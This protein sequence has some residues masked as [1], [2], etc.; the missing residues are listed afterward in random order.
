M[1]PKEIVQ[2]LLSDIRNP[3]TVRDLCAPDVTYVSL[4]YSNPDLHK[5]MPWCGTGNGVDA[6]SKT[7]HDVSEYWNVDSFSPEALFGENETVAVFG[8]FTYTSTKLRKTVTS[9]FAIFCRVQ[10]GKVTYMQFMEDTFATAAS[11]RSGGSWKFESDPH[12]GEVE[13]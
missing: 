11:F 3:K 1:K 9:P 6:I 8:K 13:I 5:I 10:N 7:F 4:N 2:S 12:G